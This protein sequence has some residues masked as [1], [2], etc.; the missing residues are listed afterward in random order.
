MFFWK[1]NKNIYYEFIVSLLFFAVLFFLSYIQ[2]YNSSPDEH[3][4]YNVPHFIYQYGELPHGGDP[5]IRNEIWGFGYAFTPI[6][7]SVVSAF[8]M[9][10]VSLF[11]KESFPLV[12]GA[13]L[14]SIFS[15]SASVFFL[16][17]IGRRLFSDSHSRCLFVLSVI[18]L[19][20]FFFLGTY[21]N[22]DSFVIL[23]SA[24]IIHAWLKG[25]ESKW[26]LRDALYLALGLSLCS[27]SYYNAY[28]YLLASCV[29]F[30]VSFI[31]T[32]GPA[33]RW[34]EWLKK[35]TLIAVAVFLLAGWAFIRN[36]VV[37]DGDIFGLKSLNYYQNL[38]AIESCKP[39]ALAAAVQLKFNFSSFLL[40][41]KWLK[42]TFC[43]FIGIFG[44]LNILLPA[45]VYVL[46]L[47][48]WAG[49]TL[50]L[51]K[52]VKTFV[53][54]LFNKK[55]FSLMLG[56]GVV[57]NGALIITII[58][59]FFLHFYHSFFI[60]FQ[61]QGRYIIP[62]LIPLMIF[63]TKGAEEMITSFGKSAKIRKLCYYT[64]YGVIL[65]VEGVAYL[66]VYIP[67]YIK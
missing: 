15:I 36:Y 17:R 64:L 47:L 60:D 1:K 29:L 18:L 5:R 34:K 24:V 54:V 6:F 57:L 51:L 2:P 16:L 55:E 12:M 4:R 10:V 37:Y 14:F 42:W 31:D 8:F 20:S 66:G 67:H 32:S 21:V 23:S 38:Y 48:L 28:G 45:V 61:A 49:E 22:R 7:T 39:S 27:L 35:G 53:S 58:I 11:S 50:G 46:M 56:E 30:T 13:R 40:F 19:P 41:F 26:V 44:Y 43:S 25:L 3:M 9:K 52:T 62:A 59:T 33:F 65:L 63:L